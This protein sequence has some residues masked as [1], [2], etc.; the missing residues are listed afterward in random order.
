MRIYLDVCCLGRVFEEDEQPR[1]QAERAAVEAILDSAIEIVS[2][3]A[4]AY[5][6]ARDPAE[7]RRDAKTM[8][9][10][11]IRSETIKLSDSIKDRATHLASLGF[12]DLDALHIAC[13]ESAR[14]DWLL[15]T[16]DRMLKRAKRLSESINVAVEN[17][18]A[19]VLRFPPQ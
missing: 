5:E 3:D 10:D 4:V 7:E 17:P 13:A 16:D 8:L 9:D 6:V 15:T 1:I 18:V 19:W 2:S 14:C 12:G 11:D